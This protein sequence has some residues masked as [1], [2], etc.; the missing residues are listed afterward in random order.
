MAKLPSGRYVII[1]HEDEMLREG[2]V[3]SMRL[4]QEIADGL[5]PQG[6]IIE[7][8]LSGALFRIDIAA[9][10]LPFRALSTRQKDRAE[11]YRAQ[12]WPNP[13]QRPRPR[14]RK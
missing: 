12:A 14:L 3:H 11:R 10:A 9:R 7:H 5:Y 8:I 4:K 6:T 13:Q 1:E 2:L